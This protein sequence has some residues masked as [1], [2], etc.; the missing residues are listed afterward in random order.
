M[1]QEMT[2]R[3]VELLNIAL[4]DLKQ[5]VDDPFVQDATGSIHEALAVLNG[6]F[7]S[8]DNQL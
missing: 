3:V 1:N 5:G 6:E 8:F 7:S 4:R 2:N